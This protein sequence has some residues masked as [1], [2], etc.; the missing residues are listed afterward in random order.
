MSDATARGPDPAR[1]PPRRRAMSACWRSDAIASVSFGSGTSSSRSPIAARTAEHRCA[2]P[3]RSRRRSRLPER[4][5]AVGAPLSVVRCPWHKWDFEIETGRCTVDPR[6]KVRRYAVRAKTATSWSRSTPRLPTT[7]PETQGS[8]TSGGRLHAGPLPGVQSATPH[9][10]RLEL[11]RAGVDAVPLP[12]GAGAV[13]EDVAEV[14][15]AGGAGDLGADHPVARVDVCVDALERCRLDEARPARAGVELGI[16][17]EQLRP[18][19]RAAV[20]AGRLRIG[21]G[22]GERPL[23]S[24][25]PQ[26]GVLL[27]GEAGPPLGVGRVVCLFHSHDRTVPRTG[28]GVTGR[29]ARRRRTVSSQPRRRADGRSRGTRTCAGTGSAS[30]MR[31]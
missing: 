6:L 14:A 12:A 19:A 4:R 27:G 15:A 30:G 1:A 7:G 25:L 3:A 26:H 24:L 8:A 5:C 23:G 2:R 21:V 28:S 13:R 17:A 31:R 9:A 11:E 10:W 22:A 29:R 16:G 18:A 20:D